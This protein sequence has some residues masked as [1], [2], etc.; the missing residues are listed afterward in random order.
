VS[1]QQ[2]SYSSASTLLA[3]L[4]A[5]HA[6]QAEEGT[7]LDASSSSSGAAAPGEAQTNGS[8]PAGQASGSMR[9]KRKRR[10]QPEAIA[11]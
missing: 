1:P 10:P 3:V 11:A 7:A 5:L 6:P 9:A 8:A 4:E 2:D